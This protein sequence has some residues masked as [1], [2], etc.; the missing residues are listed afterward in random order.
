MNHSDAHAGRSQPRQ[1]VRPLLDLLLFIVVVISGWSVF[2]IDNDAPFHRHPD[3]A[4][5][6][7]QVLR[8]D[9]NFHHPMLMVRG[10]ERIVKILMETHGFERT[11]QQVTEIGRGFVAA[12][13]ALG[14]AMLSVLA[15]QRFGWLAALAVA[16][17]LTT[18][19]SIFHISHW[20]K[21]DPLLTMGWSALALTFFWYSRRPSYWTVALVG[22]AGAIAASGKYIG[23]VGLVVAI[24][25]VIWIGWQSRGLHAF[26]HLLLLL[27]ISLP[28]VCLLNLQILLNWGEFIAGLSREMHYVQEGHHGVRRED[29]FHTQYFS[30]LSI[31]VSWWAWLPALLGLA[32][33]WLQ[34]RDKNSRLPWP[35]LYLAALLLC[36]LLLISLSP[37]IIHRYTYPVSYFLMFY[38]AI[39]VSV[40]LPLLLQRL[41]LKSTAAMA[42][43][44]AAAIAL[45]AGHIW[46]GDL[47]GVSLKSKLA[48]YRLD[49]FSGLHQ[50]INANLPQD[51]VIY[52]AD[53]YYFPDP[54]LH[55]FKD[56]ESPIPQRILSKGDLFDYGSL[57]AVRAA[58]VTHVLVGSTRH[59]RYT[60]DSVTGAAEVLSLRE[61]KAATY[62]QLQAEGQIVY[63]MERGPESSLHPA[64]TL[65]D[66]RKPT[67]DNRL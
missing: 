14:I 17:A 25:F 6:A 12:C 9:W 51:A 26:K 16:V 40:G 28:L 30:Y 31:A 62:R 66:I 35:D 44:L 24:G 42:A 49:T 60:D 7:A 29:G 38:V 46:L 20:F 50:W 23:V 39:G 43:G 67:A 33:G 53:R 18:S 22:A 58:G 64:V 8:K 1:W 56:A 65:Y 5:K 32:A 15:R 61:R 3:E 10:T 48:A 45:C 27:G 2:T 21:E 4:G 19:G 57:D 52:Q 36:Y 13:S 55:I 11:A 37:K 54:D 34:R 47:L 59:T 63:E 41:R